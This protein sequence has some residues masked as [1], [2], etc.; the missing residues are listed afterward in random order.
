MKCQI[1]FSELRDV[2]GIFVCD[3]GHTFERSMEVVERTEGTKA[4][5]DKSQKSQSQKKI[6]FEANGMNMLALMH[7]FHVAEKH[8]ILNDDK[9]LR[10]IF[11]AV[12]GNKNNYR[13]ENNIFDSI[14]FYLILF[15][16]KRAEL[17]NISIDSPKS[18]TLFLRDF[19]EIAGLFKFDEYYAEFKNRFTDQAGMTFKYTRDCDANYFMCVRLRKI[20][21]IL[22]KKNRNCAC[23]LYSNKDHFVTYLNIILADIDIERSTRLMFYF[24]IFSTTVKENLIPEFEICSFICDYLENFEPTTD[25]NEM[26]KN[27]NKKKT[28]LSGLMNC[29]AEFLNDIEE[30]ENKDYEMMKLLDAKNVV[31]DGREFFARYLKIT[32]AHFVLELD[33]Y[34]TRVNKNL[35]RFSKNDFRD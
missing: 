29:S 13:D 12:N 22:E 33:G 25:F 19:L 10:I 32:T 34:K 3:E 7:L 18:K 20:H 26:W 6:S 35:I 28:S 5:A 11:S 17:E 31:E 8:F 4:I 24:R 14:T 9:Y 1:C 23:L 30:Y 2:D 27:Y 21:R 15:L 16:T